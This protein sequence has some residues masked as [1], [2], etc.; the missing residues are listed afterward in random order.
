MY[1]ALCLSKLEVVASTSLLLLMI[2]LGL[3]G[4]TL[5][6]ISLKLSKNLER[7]RMRWRS[8]LERVSRLFD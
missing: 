6:G 7:L 8:N 5:L 2:S 4:Y 1:V 3:D